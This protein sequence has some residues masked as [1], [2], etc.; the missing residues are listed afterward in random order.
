MDDSMEKKCR[1]PLKKIIATLGNGQT[2]KG[3]DHISEQMGYQQQ[4]KDF[5]CHGMCRFRFITQNIPEMRFI[6]T[7]LVS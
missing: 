7:N 5:Q 4:D 1:K 3:E 2:G 6:Q